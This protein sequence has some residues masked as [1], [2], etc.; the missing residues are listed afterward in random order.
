M[1]PDT[2]NASLN[3][4]SLASDGQFLYLY[5][6]KGLLKVGS[7]YGGTIKG[8]VYLHKADFHVDDRGWLGYANVRSSCLGY[9]FTSNVFYVR[10]FLLKE[11]VFRINRFPTFIVCFFHSLEK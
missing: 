8:H 4:R 3:A 1:F 10:L 7:G 11:V 5:T 6:S 9:S 2:L